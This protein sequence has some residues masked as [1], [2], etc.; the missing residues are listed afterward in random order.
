V[1]SRKI[2]SETKKLKN[3]HKIIDGNI[4]YSDLNEPN[5]PFFSKRFKITGKPDYIVRINNQFIPVEIKTCKYIHPQKNHINQLAGYCQ[6]LEDNFGGFVS[7]GI[8][9][10]SGSKQFKIL[11]NPKLRFEFE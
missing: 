8:L 10:Y 11:Y 6:L 3:K 9:V 5:K 4:I 7:Y 1:I 2:I